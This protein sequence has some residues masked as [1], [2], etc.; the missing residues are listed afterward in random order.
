M[1][2]WFCH[3]WGY[4]YLELQVGRFDNANFVSFSF[5]IKKYRDHPG[6][7]FFI[8]L[9]YCHFIL[10]F[11]DSRHINEIYPEITEMS[12][13]SQYTALQVVVKDRET[14]K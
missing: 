14:E 3:L 7:C 8:E 11:Y 10:T 13:K 12:A 6:F 9:F 2:A 5:S 1:K 4:K